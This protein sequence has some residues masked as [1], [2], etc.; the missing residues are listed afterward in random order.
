MSSRVTRRSHQLTEI[1][2][3]LSVGDGARAGG[4]IA[5]HLVEFPD[6]AVA[7]GAMLRRGRRDE[8]T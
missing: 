7:V 2:V 6:D 3:L 5:E 4:L 1:G 8:T